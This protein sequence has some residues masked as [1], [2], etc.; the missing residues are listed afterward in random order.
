MQDRVVQVMQLVSVQGTHLIV[1]VL[2]YEP[3]G[4]TVTHLPSTDMNSPVTQ[5]VQTVALV[6][7]VQVVLQVLHVNVLAL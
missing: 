6:Q 5:A 3:V 7:L 1:A 2:P 4:Q